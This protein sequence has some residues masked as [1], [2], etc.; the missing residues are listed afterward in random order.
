M[1]HDSHTYEESSN[2]TLALVLGILGI[3]VTFLAPVAWI[4]SNQELEGIAAGRRPPDGESN[5]RVGRVL[6]MVGTALLAIGL[7]V[8][9]VLTIAIA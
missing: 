5:A 8:I 9:F 4:I 3:F 7:A 2:G 6:G 1:T